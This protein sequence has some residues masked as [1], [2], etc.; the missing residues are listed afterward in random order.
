MCRP[1]LPRGPS[2]NIM[3]NCR[4]ALRKGKCHTA[5]I[6]EPELFDLAT[7]S[8]YTH[9]CHY[10]IY[11]FLCKTLYYTK[12]KYPNHFHRRITNYVINC[13]IHNVLPGEKGIWMLLTAY[14]HGKQAWEFDGQ[15]YKSTF[16]VIGNSN[17]RIWML[18]RDLVILRMLWAL[19]CLPKKEVVLAHFLWSHCFKKMCVQIGILHSVIIFFFL[20]ANN[21]DDGKEAAKQPDFNFKP[22]LVNFGGWYSFT[23]E[24][25]LAMVP[26]I[27]I[28][29]C[30]MC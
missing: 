21:S 20:E 22:Y 27:T 23:E 16:C 15:M 1:G 9:T 29:K 25:P 26:D 10:W 4:K 12:V 2:Y 13:R 19:P 7:L 30:R 6:Y 11:I 28:E 5:I 3:L 14:S 17:T 18:Q 24:H 8:N